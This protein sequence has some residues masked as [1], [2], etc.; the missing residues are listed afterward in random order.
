VRTACK[1]L[2]KHDS[3]QNGIYQSFTSFLSSHGVPK[4]SFKGNSF[5]ILFFFDAGALFY[6]APLVK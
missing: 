6:I 1:A 5:N 4:A 3:E 2:S